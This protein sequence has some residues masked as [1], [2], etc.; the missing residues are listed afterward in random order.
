MKNPTFLE[1]VIVEFYNVQDDDLGDDEIGDFDFKAS[2]DLLPLDID[3]TKSGVALYRDNDADPDNRNGVFDP[4]I[5]LPLTLDAAPLFIG[6]QGE[7]DTQILFVFS[8][9]GTDN[10][11]EAMEDQE[12]T[13]QWVPDTFGLSAN[14][15]FYGP[16]FFVVVRTSDSIDEGDDF[17][18]GLVSWG[19]N[20]PTEPDPDSFVVLPP[21]DTPTSDLAEFTEFSWG[22]RALGFITIFRDEDLPCSYYLE[23]TVLADGTGRKM[24]ARKE[25]DASG[26]NWVRS[27]SSRHL[28]TNTIT[29][30]KASETESE[31]VISSASESELPAVTPTGGFDFIIR[32]SGFGS[33]PEV[34]LNGIPLTVTTVVSGAI[35]V[36]ITEGTSLTEPVELTV[37]NPVTGG[38]ATRDDLFSLGSS[39]RVQPEISFVS[40][41]T[42]MQSDFP[43]RVFGSDF[44]QLSLIQV[45]F[46]DTVM[47][48]LAVSGDG[49]E[50]QVDFPSGGMPKTGALDVT[51]RNYKSAAMGSYEEDVLLSGFAYTNAPERPCFIA[52]AAYGTAFESRLDT[53]RTF[54]DNVLLKTAAGTALVDFYYRMSPDAASVV[55]QRPWLA[56]LVRLVL[57]PVAWVLDQPSLLFVGLLA[58]LMRR[59]WWRRA[60]DLPRP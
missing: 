37:R 24:R 57:T 53:F 21:P 13:R 56:L 51:V 40:P 25:Q 19:P 4:G 17:R 45:L 59:K 60:V 30:Q 41:T 28:Q 36:T 39:D 32:G 9:P 38:E 5:D 43:V 8:S 27:S 35:D 10:W 31:V 18:V 58:L 11:P 26:F 29:A 44:N 15:S 7:P 22:S 48:V 20:T 12:N 23:P 16:D 14:D 49:T 2:E 1:Q 46:G 50:I 6:E 42:G 54:R 33:S 55:A 47:P 52:T 34:T 3:Q